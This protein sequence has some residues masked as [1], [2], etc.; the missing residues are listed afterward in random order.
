VIPAVTHHTGDMKPEEATS[1][2]QAGISVPQQRHQ[3]THT[4][5]NPKFILSTRNA[6]REDGAETGGMANQ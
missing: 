1:Y 5:F 2:R 6:G 3:P 4:T